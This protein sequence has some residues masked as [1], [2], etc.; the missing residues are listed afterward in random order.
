MLKIQDNKITLASE[1]YKAKDYR[2]AG[3]M[4]G[5]RHSWKGVY[6]YEKTKNRSH[7]RREYVLSGDDTRIYR[8]KRGFGRRFLLHDGY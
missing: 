8:P 1:K 5:R 3:S 7:R 6:S 2:T 4:N